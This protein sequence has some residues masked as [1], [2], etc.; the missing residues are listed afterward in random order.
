MLC[1]KPRHESMQEIVLGQPVL[2]SD[3]KDASHAQQNSGFVVHRFVV[4][5]EKTSAVP[6]LG[7]DTGSSSQQQA[8]LLVQKV[9]LGGLIAQHNSTVLANQHVQ[10]NDRIV[11]VNGV[12][13]SK[14]VLYDVIAKNNS[15]TLVFERVV[16]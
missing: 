10:E 15:L 4:K 16:Y 9:K 11:A 13:G 5:V 6:M 2:A 3:Y 1:C 14:D 12:S 8:Y 7:L